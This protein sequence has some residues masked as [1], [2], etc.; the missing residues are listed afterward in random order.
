MKF[1]PF[2][3]MDDYSRHVNTLIYINYFALKGLKPIY[4]LI[5]AQFPNLSYNVNM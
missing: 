2:A 4:S 5:I 3:P 1:A